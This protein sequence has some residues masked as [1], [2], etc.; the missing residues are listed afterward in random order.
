MPRVM[1]LVELHIQ[2][3][4]G[5]GRVDLTLSKYEYAGKQEKTVNHDVLIYI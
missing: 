5:L 2:V 4:A 1:S 3:E